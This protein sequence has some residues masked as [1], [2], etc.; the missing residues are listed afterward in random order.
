MRVQIPPFSFLNYLL[1]SFILFYKGDKT[2]EVKTIYTSSDGFEFSS[3][4]K[5]REHEENK[6]KMEKQKKEMRLSL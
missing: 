3:E 5:C 6:I 2:M 4:E 1:I